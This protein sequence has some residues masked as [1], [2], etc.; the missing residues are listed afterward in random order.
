MNKGFD[1]YIQTFFTAEGISK[2]Y[3]NSTYPVDIH[4]PTQLLITLDKLGQY[5]KYKEMATKVMGWTIENMQSSQGYFYY[6]INKH[7][8][9]KIPYMRWAQAWMFLSFTVLFKNERSLYR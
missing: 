8:T 9:S 6:Q 1:Y 3:N 2:Y 5:E 4:A 7:F